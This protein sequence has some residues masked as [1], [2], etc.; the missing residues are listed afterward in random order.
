MNLIRKIIYCTWK[1]I[2]NTD[3]RFDFYYALNGRF[4]TEHKAVMCG[5]HA[6]KHGVEKQTNEGLSFFLRRSIHRLEKG[7]IM[8]PR[9][10]LFALDYIEAAVDAYG[11]LLDAGRCQPTDALIL[12]ATG[13][14]EQYFSVTT[15]AKERDAA[16]LRFRQI[17]GALDID[18]GSIG[19]LGGA[20]SET[21][22]SFEQVQ[23]LALCRRSVRWYLPRA[24]PRN[25]IDRA[26]EVAAQSPSACNRQPFEFLIF[27]DPELV[28]K[29]ASLPQGCKGFVENFP[30]VVLII[31]KLNAF[32]SEADR[33]V[34]YID[35]GLA[36][37][38]FQ[39]GLI[40]QG[41][42]SCCINWPSVKSLNDEAS[43]LLRLEP[44]EQPVMMISLGYP[45]PEG[46]VPISYK[47]KIDE[48][49]RYNQCIESLTHSRQA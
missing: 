47:K 49:R 26:I 30:C 44:Y 22:P 7:L 8:R 21:I 48:L 3:N 14:F 18:A 16:E 36:A 12:W 38:S 32:S 13:V 9:R 23:Q 37:M 6:F 41:V 43:A 5:L 11:K 31:G 20:I 33:H 10:G 28:R 2:S 15:S 25:V 1:L 46:Q 27:D 35:G 4:Q 24:V 29:V 40:S 34:I 42:G 39:Y 45:D 19:P 17:R